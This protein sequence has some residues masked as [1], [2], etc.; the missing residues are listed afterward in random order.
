MSTATV[1]TLRPAETATASAPQ[2]EATPRKRRLPF[3]PRTA[4]AVAIALVAAIGGVIWIVTPPGSVSTEAAYLEADSSTVAPRVRGLIAEVLVR[5][6]ETVRT[7]QPLIRIDDEE[8]AARQAS[9]EA[10]LRTA[11]AV[12][13]AAKA[14]F[15][16][17]R[18]QL[19][20]AN[21]DVDASRAAI[22]AADA[23]TA[24][25]AADQARFDRL[26]ESGAASRR[27]VDQARAA[28]ISAAAEGAR[29]R[30]KLGVSQSQSA[31]VGAR[32]ETL[33]A[34]LAEAEASVARARAALD[35]AEQ[36]RSHALIVSPIDGVVGDR[37]ANVGDYVQA[38]SR[39]MTIVPLGA[40][41]VTANFKETQVA[42]MIAGQ[43]ATVEVDAMPGVK[44]AGRVE[45]FAP[46]SGS[47]FSLLPFE[48]GTGNFT[49]VVQRIPVRIV[50]D[51]GQTG[52][53]RLRPGLSTKVDVDLR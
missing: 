8:F 19:R 26:A 11:E 39:L 37:K 43:H 36:D 51:P 40:L 18:A 33:D 30:A 32:E 52:L 48:P 6:N 35:L 44:F 49:K 3:S 1:E 5:D 9:A 53:D 29:V 38:G 7:G 25:T 31:A 21:S 4:I 24:R 41:Y 42:R 28:A 50:L 17:H 47:Q 2:A 13:L 45:S 46:G 10:D 20:L 34:A 22:L 27:D 23:E 16:E 15:A 12:V 14:A